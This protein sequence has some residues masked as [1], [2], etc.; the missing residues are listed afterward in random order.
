MSDDK[1]TESIEVSGVR[2]TADEVRYVKLERNGN[3]LE[4]T[5]QEPERR[6]GFQSGAND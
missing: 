1:K 4:V 5:Q 2:F 3:T 6:I